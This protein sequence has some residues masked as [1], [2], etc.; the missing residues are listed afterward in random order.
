MTPSQ[1][2]P[3]SRQSFLT[4]PEM[5]FLVFIVLVFLMGGGSRADIDSLALLRFLSACAAGLATW[6][7]AREDLARIRLP[8][9]LLAAIAA[10]GVIQLVPLPPDIWTSLPGRD[11]IARIDALV[12]L[13][14]WRPITLSPAGTYNALFSLVV[15]LAGLL[16][17]ALCRDTDL[18]L[19]AFVVMGIL[20]ALLGVLQLFSDPRSGIF[21]YE[22]TNNGSAVGLFANRNHQAVFLACCMLIA[23]YLA[24]RE[25]FGRHAQFSWL[26]WSAAVLMGLGV[27]IN[28]SRAGLIALVMVTVMSALMLGARRSRDQENA[29]SR[30]SRWALPGM[31][32]TIAALILSLFA[33]AERIPALAR[34]LED[35][36]LEDLRAKLLPILL[37]MAGDFQPWGAGLGAFEHAYR[38]REPVELLGPAYV[39][40]A[41]N[42]WLQFVIEGGLPAIGIIVLLSAA[43]VWKLWK[44]VQTSADGTNITERN[45]LGFGLLL[46]LGA[47][48]IVDYPLRVPS[49]MLLAIIALAIFLGPA[50]SKDRGNRPV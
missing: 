11:A 14:A 8:L 25:K 44:L 1:T 23:A 5:G 36:A 47:A 7:I 45:W 48:S 26:L 9:C 18:A 21:L 24:S 46:V 41:H 37:E 38:M 13:D 30:I 17:F 34:L 27:L 10:V 29:R 43:A 49:L 3:F 35:S 40:E 15:P 42:D 32:L 50:L 28:G 22:I 12:G 6:A 16:L 20:S 2:L 39:N 33:A 19:L 31:L 4:K